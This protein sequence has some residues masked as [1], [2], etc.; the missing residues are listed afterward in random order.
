MALFL[1]YPILGL[2]AIFLAL[3]G[4][5]EPGLM[6]LGISSLT[7]MLGAAVRLRLG[8]RYFLATRTLRFSV[9]ACLAL[10]S[11]AAFLASLLAPFVAPTEWVFLAWPSS[12]AG[13]LGLLLIAGSIESG[14]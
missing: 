8:A 3:A 2:P 5:S 10:G 1:T 12:V 6:V 11:L 13:A 7:G 14:A 9:L 4:P